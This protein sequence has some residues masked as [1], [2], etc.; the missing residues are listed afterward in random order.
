[1][2]KSKTSIYQ[3]LS[4][5]GA[6]AHYLYLRSDPS[7]LHYFI[8]TE[9]IEILLGEHKALCVIFL[10]ISTTSIEFKH[11]HLT[12]KRKNFLTTADTDVNTIDIW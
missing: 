12:Q 10:S 6:E 1:M 2:Y 8:S 9:V 4:D 7:Q 11:R 3:K 5:A